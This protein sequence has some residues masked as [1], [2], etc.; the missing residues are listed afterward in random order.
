MTNEQHCSGCPSDDNEECPY[1]CNGS[2]DGKDTQINKF[3]PVA[4][5][6]LVHIA[7]L[8][9]PSLASIS[10]IRPCLEYMELRAAVEQVKQGLDLPTIGV[11]P[12]H[13][14]R[15]SVLDKK[16]YLFIEKE[17]NK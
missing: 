5:D 1:L 14:G 2:C 8:I 3:N 11:S 4:I 16:T 17:A 15:G 7:D 9:A 12:L 6:R 10:N 13:H